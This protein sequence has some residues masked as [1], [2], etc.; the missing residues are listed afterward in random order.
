MS[1][2]A[3]ARD[4][5]LAQCPG[6]SSERIGIKAG[7]CSKLEVGYVIALSKDFLNRLIAQQA[8]V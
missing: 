8:R 7:F 4:H 5:S 6:L 1:Q 2:I 3:E